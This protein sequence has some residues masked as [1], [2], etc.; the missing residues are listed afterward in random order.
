MIDRIGNF[1]Q[2]QGFAKSRLPAFTQEEINKLKGSADFFGFNT[3]T[4]SLVYKNDAANTANFPEPSFDHD[5]GIIEYQDPS[6][7]ATGSTWFRVYPKGIQN[8]LNWIRKEYNNPEVYVTENGYSDRG[9]TRDEGRVDYYKQYMSAVLDAIEEGCNVKGYVAWSLMDNFEWRAGLSE[10]FGLYF[11]DYNHPNLTRVQK[12]SAKFYSN[13]VKTHTIDMKL[14]PEP[15]EYTL[16]DKGTGSSIFP[17]VSVI[18]ASFA[19]LLRQ[20]F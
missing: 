3:Y 8:L 16:Y 18:F 5:R 19:V 11:V 9:G 10:R 1:S 13:V 2:R 20:L 4:T 17:T 6:W 15:E 7:P 12:S 14:M